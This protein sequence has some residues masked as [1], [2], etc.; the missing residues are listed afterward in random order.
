LCLFLFFYLDPPHL[1]ELIMSALLSSASINSNVSA[2]SSSVVLSSAASSFG[3][4][5]S[6]LEEFLESIVLV[7]VEMKRYLALMRELDI[8]CVK[9]TET[10]ALLQDKYF[11]KLKQEG[12][13]GKKEELEQLMK[14]IKEIRQR[15][16]QK[17]DEKRSI[18]DQLYETIDEHVN[19]AGSDLALLESI[20]KVSGSLEP[21]GVGIGKLV[22]AC[23]TTTSIGDASTDNVAGSTSETLWILGRIVS[24]SPALPERCTVAD[25][26]N[27]AN[28]YVLS[29]KNV[30]VLPEDGEDVQAARDRLPP[31]GKTAMAI[32]PNTTSFYEC[33]LVSYPYRATSAADEEQFKDRTVVAVEFQDDDDPVTGL[34]T[35]RIIPTIC[36][37]A[38]PGSNKRRR[39]TAM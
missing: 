20:L 14:M 22:A 18:A 8:A 10:L 16:M 5:A 11:T 39:Q 30:V 37:F 7:P 12:G 35:R 4:E 19:K 17:I 9:D 21:E 24:F 38:R 25:V 34:P 6:I 27:D 15:L 31:K 23:T 29:T 2:A 13:G 1:I 36:V 3:G 28:T 33:T 32:Y 26:D